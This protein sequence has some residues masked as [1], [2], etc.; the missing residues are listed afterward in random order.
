MVKIYYLILITCDYQWQQWFV[1]FEV[2]LSH[3]MYDA[4]VV[5]RSRRQK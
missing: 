5:L 4:A 2:Y 3:R 1:L